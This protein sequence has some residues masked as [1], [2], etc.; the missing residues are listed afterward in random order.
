MG[1]IRRWGVRLHEKTYIFEEMDE[2][3][4]AASPAFAVTQKDFDLVVGKLRDTGIFMLDVNGRIASWNAGAQ[5]LVGYSAEE[6]IGRHFA[7]LYSR[8]DV[9]AGVCDHALGEALRHGRFE[10]EGFRV[11]RDGSRFW[12]GIIVVPLHAPDD[13]H[14]GFV[15]IT[16]D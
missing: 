11:R 2:H 9:A 5:A 14:Q 7:I 12:A 4:Q 6:I 10:G 15:H 16:R 8:A 13:T 3:T 1:R